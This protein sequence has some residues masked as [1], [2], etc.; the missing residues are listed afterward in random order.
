MSRSLGVADSKADIDEGT[1]TGLSS[2]GTATG[3]T[4][5]FYGKVPVV[6]R[7]YSSALHATSGISSSADF[8]ATQ[9]AWAQ[10]VQ[11]TLIGIGVWATV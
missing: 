6:Q 7:P 2:L 1:V 8:G 3:S 10:E 4:V 5:G 11:K 9:L